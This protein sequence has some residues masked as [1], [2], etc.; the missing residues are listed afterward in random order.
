M[1]RKTSETNFWCNYARASSTLCWPL[2][3][4]LCA[5]K[6]RWV[7]CTTNYWSWMRPNESKMIRVS[8]RKCFA[9]SKLTIAF[10]WLARPCRTTWMNCGHYSTSSCPF[11][12]TLRKTS[13]LC[14]RWISLLKR[15]S[16]TSSK[17]KWSS[18]YIACFDLSCWGD[19]SPTLRLACHAKK[20]STS[21][22]VWARCRNNCTRVSFLVTSTWSTRLC[23][24]ELTKSNC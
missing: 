22:L 16:S 11:F 10:C 14:S 4:W 17:K 20:R 8:F 1:V 3:R 13:M 24:T 21:M 15:R 6:W 23:P 9:N 19:S 12:S 18:K 2:S 5:K 7:N